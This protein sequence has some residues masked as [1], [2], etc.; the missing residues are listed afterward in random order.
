MVLMNGSKKA[1]NAASIT[2]NTKIFGIMGGLAPRTGLT[3]SLR[4]HILSK[5]TVK[6]IIPLGEAGYVY[7]RDNNLLSK[8]PQCSGGVG[9]GKL[10]MCY[11]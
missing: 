4:Q 10:F 6:N 11:R 7:M 2:N 9:K 8:N 3:T 1:R 5:A